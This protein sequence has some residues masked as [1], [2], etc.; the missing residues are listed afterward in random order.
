MFYVDWE[1]FYLKFLDN[2]GFINSYDCNR[3]VISVKI[4]KIW[5][6]IDK[7]VK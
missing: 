1:N 5:M 3:L 4:E 7:K 6:G 2:E